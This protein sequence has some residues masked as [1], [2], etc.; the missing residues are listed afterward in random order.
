MANLN[1]D[2]QTAEFLQGRAMA[3]GISVDQFL[4]QLVQTVQMH[5]TQRSTISV[6]ELDR[7]LD[8]EATD[9]PGL[10]A[11]FSRADIYDEHD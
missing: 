2:D 9:T 6:E 11:D 8:A 7:L 5:E 1:L 3:L 10:P 4:R